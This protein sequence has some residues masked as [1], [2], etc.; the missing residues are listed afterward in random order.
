MAR[1]QQRLNRWFSH[2]RDRLPEF[3]LLLT[4][5]AL[6]TL[7]LTVVAPLISPRRPGPSTEI[8]D[9]LLKQPEQAPMSSA[10]PPDMAIPSRKRAQPAIE[11]RV[12]LQKLP[13]SVLLRAT[14]TASLQKTDGNSWRHLPQRQ[15]LSCESGALRMEGVRG[16]AELWLHPR[17]G[18]TTRVG[19]NSYR[20]R[21]RFLC[22]GELLRVINHIPLE[23]YIASVVGAEMPSHW[24]QEALQ[25]QAVAARSYAMAHLARPADRNW[26][27]GDTTRWQAYKGLTSE[28]ERG[29]EA[30]RATKGLILS[31]NGGIVESL[32]AANRKLSLEAHGRLGA[33][34]SQ[35][36]A[37][38]L[39]ENGYR[40]T[41][42]LATYYPGA[43][44]ARLERR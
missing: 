8:V 3:L 33:S 22:H 15:A 10:A 2:C 23:D 42:I 30:A 7:L 41:Q 43:S 4:P 37:H 13:A 5:L 1:Q 19:A 18:M 12:L 24:H 27:L 40:Y 44:L 31:I 25:A 35:R 14:G 38:E 29:R 26:T 21:F 32:Y 17:P 36:G 34:M 11:I 9:A 16:P 39:A 20:G 6:S 28:S